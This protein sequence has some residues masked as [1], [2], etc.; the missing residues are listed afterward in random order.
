MTRRRT[1]L[2]ASD[3][4]APNTPRAGGDERLE[5]LAATVADLVLAELARP[6][7]PDG[8]VDAAAVARHLSVDAGWVYAHAADLSARRLGGGPKARLRFRL[9]D[10]D[11]AVEAM[12]V[13]PEGRESQGAS[14]RVTEPKRRSRPKPLSGT[15]VPL[16]P[17]KSHGVGG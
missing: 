7:V 15:G 9:A 11:A 5:L 17:V 12:T 4:D 1:H 16:L 6:R 3:S 13:R 8:W 14:S 2:R 10:V